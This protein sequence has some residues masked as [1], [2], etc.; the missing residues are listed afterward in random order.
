MPSSRRRSG[1]TLVELLVVIGIIAILIAILLPGLSAARR[2]SRSVK[3]L[4]NLR[5]LGI[6][7]QMYAQTFNG[8]WPV[9]RHDPGNATYPLPATTSLR[10]QD[11]IL[12]FVSGIKGANSMGDLNNNTTTGNNLDRLK[13]ASVLWGCP[14]YAK[15]SGDDAT[16]GADYARTGYAMNP[17]ARLPEFNTSKEFAFI[18]ASNTGRYTKAT[19][20]TKPSDRLLIADAPA[21]YISL[22]VRTRGGFNSGYQWWPWPSGNINN[23]ATEVHFWVDGN[24]HGKPGTSKQNQYRG[25]KYINALFCDG[26]VSNVSV[27]EAWNAIVNPGEDTAKP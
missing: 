14:E 5:Q 22:S 8:K 2:Q 25:G 12:E 1:F 24:R 20:W 10:W 19:E 21:D 17:Y 7:F 3:C 6:G 4:S 11:R 27:A 15:G 23:I 16:T 13:E 9:V 18:N 26:H